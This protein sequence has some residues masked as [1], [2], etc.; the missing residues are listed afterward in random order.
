MSDINHSNETYLKEMEKNAKLFE[1]KMNKLEQLRSNNLIENENRQKIMK[2]QIKSC[3]KFQAKHTKN[4]NNDNIN[5][6][7]IKDINYYQNINAN[8]NSN[9]IYI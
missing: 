2:K 1:E 7:K 3:N 6:N 8:N 5:R 4:D 9:N